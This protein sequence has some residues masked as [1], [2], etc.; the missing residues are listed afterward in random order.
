[1]QK[2]MF[3]LDGKKYEADLDELK[4]YKTSK[5]F[6]QGESNPSGMFDA[7]SRI[8][9]GN[10]EKY[11]EEIGGGI[12]DMGKLCNAAFEAAKLKNS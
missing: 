8:F 10:D 12:E 7:M 9:M 11:I 2:I 4:S 5:Q 6:A 1:M 3:E